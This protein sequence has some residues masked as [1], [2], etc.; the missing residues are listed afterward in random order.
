MHDYSDHDLCEVLLTAAGYE[1]NRRRA[2]VSP[3]DVFGFP[4][5]AVVC[6][7]DC[8][9]RALYVDR[10]DRVAIDYCSALQIAHGFDARRAAGLLV[11]TLGQHNGWWHNTPLW[12]HVICIE[13]RDESRLDARHL[14]VCFTVRND[15]LFLLHIARVEPLDRYAYTE[16]TL[17]RKSR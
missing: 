13:G 3:G 2:P 7:D 1:R 17:I 4:V 12:L 15:L 5:S 10:S 11:F 14:P 6:C 8:P 16:P 9:V